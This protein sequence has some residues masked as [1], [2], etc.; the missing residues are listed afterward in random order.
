VGRKAPGCAGLP[1][2]VWGGDVEPGLP[3]H[4]R[5]HQRKARRLVRAGFFAVR[6][7]REGPCPAFASPL[8]TGERLSAEGL[9]HR[10]LFPFVRERPSERAVDPFGGRRSAVPNGS[11]R[12][13]RPTA[14]GPRRGIRRIPQS[15]ARRGV[16]RCGGGGRRRKRRGVDPRPG[17]P[18][19]RGDG[20]PE[21]PCLHPRCVRSRRLHPR[22]SRAVGERSRRG[23]PAA[24][25]EP[26]SRFSRHHRES[27]GIPFRLS[28]PSHR[29]GRR[30][31]VGKDGPR[32]DIP[33]MPEDV[34]VLRR[35]ARLPGIPR[36]APALRAR[37]RRCRMAPPP[38]DRAD[39]R[40]G[41]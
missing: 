30:C 13:R 25:H 32:G 39:R 21:N 23:R 31:R 16:R 26:P 5:A 33:G 6:G 3:L 9:R 17:R 11:R 28:P 27:G 35:R 38:Q 1:E 10:R 22:I 18:S 7:G 8:H 34:R 15:R 20:I 29:D 4:P 37:R 40:C 24:G 36:D 41:A 2:P 12:I 14:P 19:P